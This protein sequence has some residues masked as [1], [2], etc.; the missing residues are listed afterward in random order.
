M[1]NNNI[2]LKLMDVIDEI[3]NSLKEDIIY[4]AIAGPIV[5]IEIDIIDSKARISVCLNIR[6][7]TTIAT[8]TVVIMRRLNRI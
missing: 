3:L 1:D 2:C 6:I 5:H 4:K 7:L 8:A